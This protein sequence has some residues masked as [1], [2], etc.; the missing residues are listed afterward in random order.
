[1][2]SIYIV[3][4]LVLFV[5]SAHLLSAIEDFKITSNGLNGVAHS[6]DPVAIDYSKKKAT[7]LVFL[8]SICPC[9]D[10]H[11]S[12]VKKLAAK[13]PAFQFV[14]I[15]SNHNE[16]KARALAYFKG[17]ELGFPVIHDSESIIGKSLG[18]VKTPHIFIKD[19]K[20]ET[21]YNGSVT[22]SSNAKTAKIQHLA[23]A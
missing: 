17:K 1:M 21:I 13:N 4:S 7:I 6:G 11:T 9:S 3:L 15:H 5:N 23:N 18:A 2:K 20:G 19:S 12:I 10:S 22:D 14:G 8:S 16:N